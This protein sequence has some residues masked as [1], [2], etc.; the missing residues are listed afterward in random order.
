MAIIIDGE[1]NVNSGN[2]VLEFNPPGAPPK[3]EEVIEPKLNPA[4]KFD[5]IE[6]VNK[7]NDFDSNSEKT[8]TVNI[9]SCHLA[10]IVIWRE[11]HSKY[12]LPI[13]LSLSCALSWGLDRLEDED[14][15]KE[16]DILVDRA[17]EIDGIEAKAKIYKIV[18]S[19]KNP[20]VSFPLPDCQDVSQVQDLPFKCTEDVRNKLFSR[21]DKLGTSA[22]LLGSILIGYALSHVNGIDKDFAPWAID[23]YK[24]LLKKISHQR[25]SVKKHLRYYTEVSDEKER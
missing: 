17:N 13:G 6:E 23:N 16:Y 20:V 2:N 4:Y 10:I 24:L 21:A 25:K 8:K 9:S 19:M 5:L 3:Q 1:A 12:K 7:K 15:I 14:L 18:G 22:S 11:I